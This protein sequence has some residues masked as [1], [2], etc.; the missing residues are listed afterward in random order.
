MSEHKSITFCTATVYNLIIMDL[1][2]PADFEFKSL[3]M[4]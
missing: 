4:L 1:I 3:V 2:K